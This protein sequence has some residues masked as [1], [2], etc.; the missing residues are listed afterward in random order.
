MIIERLS[1]EH[2][3]VEALLSVLERELEIFDRG[4]RPDYEVIRGISAISKFIR[5]YTIIPRKIWSLPSSQFAIQPRL[6][7]S[8]AW[9]LSTKRGLSVCVVSRRQ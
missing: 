3:N 4:G 9:H 5:R 2:R 1:R 8:V 7:R 6:S